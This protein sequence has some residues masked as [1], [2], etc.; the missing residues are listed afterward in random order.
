MRK[1]RWSC[2]L[3]CFHWY[4]MMRLWV[5]RVSNS[6]NIPAWGINEPLARQFSVCV[7]Y[8]FIDILRRHLGHRLAIYLIRRLAFWSERSRETEAVLHD[9]FLRERGRPLYIFRTCLRE[10]GVGSKGGKL[11]MEWRL[12]VSFY[13][14]PYT[15][16]YQRPDQTMRCGHCP[17]PWNPENVWGLRSTQKIHRVV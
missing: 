17:S 3:S 7:W 1:V 6:P 10:N 9:R 8:F 16:G 4:S 15:I 2:F 13:S 5:V 12:H 14:D 11:C